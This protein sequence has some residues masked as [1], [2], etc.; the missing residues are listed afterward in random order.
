MLGT[1]ANPGT[2]I[3][4]AV[5]HSFSFNVSSETFDWNDCFVL[6]E[7]TTSGSTL[8]NITLTSSV[9]GTDLRRLLVD[10]GAFA[11]DGVTFNA[12]SGNRVWAYFTAT[13]KTPYSW[14][15]ALDGT[16]FHT[17]YN[18]RDG[19]STSSGLITGKTY[20]VRSI[21]PSIDFSG[22]VAVSL[23]TSY[24]VWPSS[25]SAT[26][27][28]KALQPTFAYWKVQIPSAA[29]NQIQ[30]HNLNVKFT[31]GNANDRVQVYTS[32]LPTFSPLSSV[33][34]DIT[35]GPTGARAAIPACAVDNV[36]SVIYVVVVYAPAG[37]NSTSIEAGSLSV[38]ATIDYTSSPATPSAASSGATLTVGNTYLLS[39]LV[40]GDVISIS[41][42]GVAYRWGTPQLMTTDGTNCTG[43]A[44]L[45]SGVSVATSGFS[46]C[47]FDTA[48]SSAAIQLVTGSGQG[49]LTRTSP[50]SV[51]TN[52]N[53]AVG[54]VPTDGAA[55]F[56]SASTQFP[57]AVTISPN[58]AAT[59]F[60]DFNRANTILNG[61]RCAS[62]SLTSFTQGN[63]P[64]S[65]VVLGCPGEAVKITGFSRAFSVKQVGSVGT[66]V[67]RTVVPRTTGDAHSFDLA[68]NT[69]LM[70]APQ[71]FWNQAF[72]SYSLVPT[73]AVFASI[74]PACC[75]SS[76]MPTSPTRLTRFI[77]EE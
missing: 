34:T 40:A 67:T 3:D 10:A 68:P 36:N 57:I 39:N 4:T 52:G 18:S 44:S 12:A 47:D 11:F 14:A 56:S 16:P 24:Q 38:S 54:T 1:S 19:L 42:S 32:S 73:F 48:V 17:D 51:P 28:L 26:V 71:H 72:L 62:T 46:T 75:P 64:E 13:S 50:T 35:P 63:E 22:S 20:R 29:S 27:T 33:R 53:A 69:P 30:N 70:Y 6:T 23:T 65:L 49:T 43:I 41:G 5:S 59:S 58:S 45:P 31:S 8:S 60:A 2:S 25:G 61:A 76:L 21:L 77:S 9:Y 74:S 7:Y 37:A 15:A 55:F 66:T